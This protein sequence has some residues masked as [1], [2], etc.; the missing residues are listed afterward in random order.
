MKKVLLALS[1]VVMV[2][3][4][5]L[6]AQT[7][8]ITG[9]VT[10]AGDGFP[11]PGVSVFIKGTTVGTVTRPDGTYSL[12][13]PNDATTLVFSFVG[14]TTQEV[15]VEGRTSISVA[16]KSDAI[17]VDEVIVVAYGTAKKESFTGSAG[18]VGAEKLEKRTMTSVAQALEGS[19]TGI[20]IAGA[21]GQPGE[22]P[23]VRIRGFGSLNG[24]SEPLYIVDGIQFEGNLADLS[25]DDI[26]SMTILKDAS[27]AALYGSRAANGV[28][29]IT[30][31]SGRKSDGKVNIEL[32][33]VGGVV[34]QGIPYYE[35]VGA[36]DYYE[37]M[38]EAYK[39]AEIAGGAS[40]ETAAATAASGIY[41]KLGYNPFDVAND[42]IVGVDGRI[43]PN[44]NIIAPDLDW[45]EPLRQTGYRQNYNLSASGGGDK[46]DYFFSLGY[47]DETGYVVNSSFERISSRMNINVTPKD[48]VKLGT[49]LSWSYTD[50]ENTTDPDDKSSIK[51]PFSFA[52]YMGPIYPV[53]IAD[54]K[55]GEY[56][57]DAAGDKQY[58]LGV[59]Y[60]EYGIN[61]RPADANNGRH[62]PAEL[63]YNL[64]RGR[65]HAISN[66]SYAQFNIMEG[67]SATTNIGID[68]QSYNDKEFENSI[69]GDGAPGGRYRE[70]RYTQTAIN[71]TQLVNYTK[72]INDS[73]NFEALVGHE[74]YSLEYNRMYGMKSK[75]TVS[76]INEFDNFVTPTS[77]DGKTDKKRTEGYFGRLKYNFLNKYYFE[78]SFRRDGS[79]V[80]HK[81][82]RWGNF[83][84][85]GAT[86]RMDQEAFI[87]NIS[88]I[89]QLKMRVSYGEV[90]NDRLGPYN[91]SYYAHQA[92]YDPFP[93]GTESGLRWSTTG[94]EQL[95]W[96][97]NNS[98][99]AAV[100]YNLLGGKLHGAVE[101]YH[102]ISEDLLYNMPLATSMGLSTQPRN[103]ATLYNRGI[104]VS[105][106]G[107]LVRTADFSWD[108]EI[109]AST[110]KNEITEIPT[111][112]ISGSKRW[113]EGHSVY[114]YYLYD[115]F[116]VDEA[117]GLPQ[118]QLFVEDADGVKQPQ[119]DEEGDPVF[120]DD[121]LKSDLVYTGDSSI[122]DLFG[123]V[124]NSL[125]YKGFNLSF[126][127]TYS[128]GGKILDYNYRNLMHEGDYGKAF[129]VD[130]LN[131]WRNAGDKTSI[132]KLQY[133][134]SKINPTSAR[135]LT[136][137]SYL[138][139]KNVNLSYTFNKSMLSGLGINSMKIFASGENLF[140]VTKRKGLNPQEAFSGTTSDVYLPSRI[141]SLGVNL[142]F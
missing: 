6:M 82:V 19:T 111:P 92:L 36:K 112:F 86:W 46:H 138:S 89:D 49:N 128:I 26:Q 74:S 136:D 41:G 44:A 102:K 5:A 106:G 43:N 64:N 3:L 81:D 54:P 87:E 2:G 33:A 132:P 91:S 114:D 17:D 115:Y 12:A 23:N 42:A 27:S 40:S 137:A 76:G 121:H 120:T 90:G 109:Q 135:W 7:T 47:L 48:W 8:N 50:R 79:S 103:I 116:G 31:K 83:Y 99:D 25:P 53:Y 38:F 93:N 15:A 110:V 140:I 105:V 71:W 67:L 4:Q 63:D 22:A 68:V 61:S 56:I 125:N 73:H 58:D 18:V 45:Y 119:F 96:E 66:R 37:L 60:P 107:A 80:F 78:G 16:L 29:M 24:V 57:L 39:N 98:F 127:F 126:L 118:Y 122:P 139:L 28:I 117:T 35:T 85:V 69:V 129:H 130:Q 52:R 133:G 84:S 131:G 11:I 51:N 34:S 30:T 104:E 97:S 95:T 134:N 59:G 62:V 123:S 77:L 65:K 142:S 108:M 101:F 75:Q 9:T 100:E 94:N 88:W 124:S 21:S 20:Q 55:T 14:M 113:D 10:D 141:V 70:S 13:V 72:T 1:L 32:K